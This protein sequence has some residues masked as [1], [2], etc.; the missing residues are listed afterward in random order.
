MHVLSI[1]VGV[2]NLGVC[3]YDVEKGAI[4]HADAT[5][6]AGSMREIAG[7]LDYVLRLVEMCSN[8]T[9]VLGSMLARA[10]VVIV[11]RQMKRNMLIIQ[12]VLAAI[13]MMRGKRVEF[14]SPQSVK[15]WFRKRLGIAVGPRSSALC[16]HRVN[17]ME[18]KEVFSVMFPAFELPVG[19]CDDVADATL[20]AAFWS[21]RQQAKKESANKRARKPT[22]PSAIK[23]SAK[24]PKVLRQA[25]P[26]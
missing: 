17:K 23:P 19:K 9:S 21:E 5:Q 14:V 16:Y 3:L 10:D 12:H 1:D 18:A 24:K 4:V 11:E 8:P 15:V 13:G 6:L 7:E 2:V 22:K 20:Q 25:D 26:K